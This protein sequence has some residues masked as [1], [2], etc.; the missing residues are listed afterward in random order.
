MNMQE[1]AGARLALRKIPVFVLAGARPLLAELHTNLKM[2]CYSR[3][4]ELE[5]HIYFTFT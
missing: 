4:E 5:M 1:A 2:L 3:Y